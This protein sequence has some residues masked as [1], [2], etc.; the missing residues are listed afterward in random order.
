MGPRG[1]AGAWAVSCL[2][3]IY[4]A[5]FPTAWLLATSLQVCLFTLELRQELS[6]TVFVFLHDSDTIE[7]E[8][9]EC[10]YHLYY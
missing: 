7:F 10:A 9:S 2:A 1:C 4:Q 3:C 6:V 8:R 5:K